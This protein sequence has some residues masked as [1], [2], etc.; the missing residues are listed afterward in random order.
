MKFRELVK[1]VQ[2]YSGFSDQESQE[3]LEMMVESLAA[4]LKEDERKDFAAQLPDEL[5]DI[6]LSTDFSDESSTDIVEH[7]MQLHEIE[8]PRAKKQISSSWKALKDAI[9]EGLVR[10]IRSQLPDRMVGFLR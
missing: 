4:H 2:L 1:R 10:H 5:Q 3:A 9:S 6:A 8:E 7:F